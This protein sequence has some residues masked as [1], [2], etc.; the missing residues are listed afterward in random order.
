MYSK[1][2]IENFKSFSNLK[3]DNLGKIN[4]FFGSNNCGK[5][6]LLESI[7][8][9]SGMSNPAL[10]YKCNQF[11]GFPLI[12]DIS[13]FF[14]NF[15]TDSNILIQSEIDSEGSSRK[16][17]VYPQTKI[18]KEIKKG[19][20]EIVTNSDNSLAEIS[21]LVFEGKLKNKEGNIESVKT[22]MRLNEEK[23][24]ESIQ[25]SVKSKYKET[26]YCSYFSP[27]ISLTTIIPSVLKIFSDK[28]EQLVIKALKKIDSRIVDFILNDNTIMVDVGFEKRLPINLLGDGVRKFFT[29]VVAMYE[30]KDGILLVDEIDNGL[31]FS[32]MEKFWQVLLNTSQLFNVQLFAT[33]HNID[34]IKGLNKIL[35]NNEYNKYQK[36]VSAYKLLRR[37]N[38]TMSALYYDYQSFSELINSE[39]EIR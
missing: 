17:I 9:L 21:E 36:D 1:L 18:V 35:Q 26:L 12:R 2:K 7:F 10:L 30:C 14:H 38:D 39:T 20:N 32:A 13:L 31:H 22:S 6:T 33:T 11:R 37:D 8:I 24:K 15:N 34:S 5:T 23:T 25:F 27:S 3:I 19:T 29:L 4:L 28:K 16:L